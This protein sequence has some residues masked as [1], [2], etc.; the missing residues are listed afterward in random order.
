[1]RVIL[2]KKKK[3]LSRMMEIIGKRKANSLNLARKTRKSKK[4]EIL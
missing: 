3:K 4:G 2:I 1:V